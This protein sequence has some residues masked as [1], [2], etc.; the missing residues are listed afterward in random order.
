MLISHRCAGNGVEYHPR[1]VQASTKP[2]K[3]SIVPAP[4]LL[5]VTAPTKAK[6]QLY[7]AAGENGPISH[8]WLVMIKRDYAVR[9]IRS[10]KCLRTS[11]VMQKNLGNTRDITNNML[12]SGGKWPEYWIAKNVSAVGVY[13]NGG[14]IPLEVGDNNVS[15]GVKDR[16]ESGNCDVKGNWLL[17]RALEQD[18][19]YRAFTRAFIDTSGQCAK[20]A[21]PPVPVPPPPRDRTHST[22]WMKMEDRHQ[23]SPMMT[24]FPTN[25]KMVPIALLYAHTPHCS[26][27]ASRYR[28]IKGRGCCRSSR[29]Q[30]MA[31]GSF[32]GVADFRHHSGNA[33]DLLD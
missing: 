13:E 32:A 26:L 17:F 29:L 9:R 2:G 27:T 33:S 4:E 3:P 7:G 8:Y 28:F 31:A 22:E 1:E 30:H 15:Y 6:I 24:A 10:E 12:E 19:E 5:E 14:S 11:V 21:V 18:T 20:C 23:D 16:C 25:S